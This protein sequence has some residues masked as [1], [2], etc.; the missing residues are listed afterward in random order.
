[1]SL[2]NNLSNEPKKTQNVTLIAPH[3]SE[4]KLSPLASHYMSLFD[5]QNLNTDLLTKRKNPAL[6]DPI[7][8]ELQKKLKTTLISNGIPSVPVPSLL[9]PLLKQQQFLPT[10]EPKNLYQELSDRMNVLRLQRLQNLSLLLSLQQAKPDIPLGFPSL[11]INNGLISEKVPL[12][13]EK[14]NKIEERCPKREGLQ[15]KKSPQSQGSPLSRIS[16]H[17]INHNTKDFALEGQE[18]ILNNRP[19][20]SE[21]TRRFPD[22][23]LSTIFNYIK[24]GKSLEEFEKEKKSKIVRP[25]KSKVKTMKAKSDKFQAEKVPCII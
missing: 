25:K 16:K 24:S 19:V 3:D 14:P 23:D 20:L 11:L 13:L 5:P 10:Q 7:P 6:S 8:D 18:D 4:T 9:T 22:W 15:Q 1:M 17:S 2:S 21:F 12:I